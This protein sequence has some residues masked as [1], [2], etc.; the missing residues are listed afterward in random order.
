MSRGV[1]AVILLITIW[2]AHIILKV[3]GDDL[4]PFGNIKCSIGVEDSIGRAAKLRPPPYFGLY[5]PKL[6]KLDFSN[7]F[8]L[9]IAFRCIN[10]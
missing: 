8:S 3:A 9:S 1:D 6:E 5:F 7:V 10:R 4:V 2:V